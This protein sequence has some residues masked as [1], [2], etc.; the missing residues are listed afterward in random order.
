MDD[1]ELTEA[2]SALRTVKRVASAVLGAE[3]V[4]EGALR[5]NAGMRQAEDRLSALRGQER[6]LQIDVASVQQALDTARTAAAAE[7]LQIGQELGQLREQ[8]AEARTQAET[9]MVFA[10][11]AAQVAIAAAEAD[12]AQ[13]LVE[14]H[15]QV[16]T[17]EASVSALRAQQ[18]EFV[19][20][21]QSLA[22]V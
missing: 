15:L 9:E 7:T 4:I 13:R 12:T 10:R 19:S 18:A 6:M 3:G 2:L 14:L 20:K 21:A 17:L 16:E 11:R 22:G 5:A 1:Q 8:L